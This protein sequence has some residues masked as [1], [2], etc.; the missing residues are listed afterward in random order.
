MEYITDSNGKKISVSYF[1]NLQ[2][3]IDTCKGYVMA[4]NNVAAKNN[5]PQIDV[6]YAINRIKKAHYNFYKDYE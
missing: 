5:Q 1:G 2:E 6:N 4:Y 3:K